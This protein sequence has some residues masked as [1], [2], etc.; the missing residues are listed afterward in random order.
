MTTKTLRFCFAVLAALAI[1]SVALS[2]PI[3]LKDSILTDMTLD[4][5]KQYLLKGFF[6]VKS[7]ATITIPSGTVI[8]GDKDSK[9]S[10]IIERG[11]KIMASGT[12][13]HP[14]VFTSSQPAG[15]RNTGDWGGILIA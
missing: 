11:A 14:I 2:Q 10:L 7:G 3:E 5:T 1:Q 8:M 4:S 15:S 13:T 6:K 9:G 12:A